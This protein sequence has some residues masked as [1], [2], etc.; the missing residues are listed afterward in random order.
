MAEFAESVAPKQ[1]LQVR[2]RVLLYFTRI[3]EQLKRWINEIDEYDKYGMFNFR[4]DWLNIF[5]Y[6]KIIKIIII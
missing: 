6:A 4:N 3:I 2:Y 5:N 1:C